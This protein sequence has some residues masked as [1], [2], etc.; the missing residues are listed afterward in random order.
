MI[1]WQQPRSVSDGF[2]KQMG[3]VVLQATIVGCILIR[4]DLFIAKQ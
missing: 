4:S 1:F 2:W 3:V